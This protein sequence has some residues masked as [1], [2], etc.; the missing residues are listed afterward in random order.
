[1]EKKFELNSDLLTELSVQPLLAAYLEINHLKQ[2]YRQGWLRVGVSREQ[3]ES[4]ADHIYAMSMLVWLVVDAGLA[5]G[6]DRDKALR[7]T[8]AHE[9][10]EIYTGD[11]IPGDRVP[12]EEKQRLEREALLNVVG[13]LPFGQEYVDLWEE[14]EAGDS[15]EARL[16]RQLDRLEMA[17]QALVYEKQEHRNMGSFYHS[18]EEAVRSPELTELLETVQSLR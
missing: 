8:L 17:L 6:A 9:L 18:A 15:P 11:I 10:G 2:L 16:V 14:F 3:C 12:P 1:M 7:M 13:K 4:V 5:P